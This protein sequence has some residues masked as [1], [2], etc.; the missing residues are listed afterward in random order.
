MVAMQQTQFKIGG[1]ASAPAENSGSNTN[2][3]PQ[4]KGI[5]FAVPWVGQARAVTGRVAKVLVYTTSIGV[6]ARGEPLFGA[7]MLDSEAIG[8]QHKHSETGEVPQV[9]TGKVIRVWP[10]REEGGLEF[11]TIEAQEA[12]ANPNRPA[13]VPPSPKGLGL[14]LQGL[15]ADVK[16]LEEAAIAGDYATVMGLLQNISQ[17]ADAANKYTWRLANPQ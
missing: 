8:P 4:A 17:R 13:S 15:V 10:A 11:V 5:R 12:P 14:Q 9:K 7:A 1:G 3:T 16:E 6:N 2:N